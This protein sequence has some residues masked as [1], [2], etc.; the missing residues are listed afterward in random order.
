MIARLRALAIN[1]GKVDADFPLRMRNAQTLI[2]LRRLDEI[3]QI[4][5]TA[6]DL[7]T[8]DSFRSAMIE[9]A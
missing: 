4:L 1:E 7:R 8:T 5:R 3:H 6:T 9:W 2:Y